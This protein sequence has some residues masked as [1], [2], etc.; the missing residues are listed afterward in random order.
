M[1][2]RRHRLTMESSV[3]TKKYFKDGKF[4]TGFTLFEVLIVVAILA[5]LSAIAVPDFISFLK[6]LNLDND[7]QEFVSVLRLAQNRALSS[8]N[9]MQY[10]VYIDTAISPNRYVLFE[11]SNYA[12]RNI[13]NDRIYFLEKANEFYNVNLG[14]GNEIV[15]DKLTGAPEESGSVSI[16]I[17]ID[18]SYSTVY[19]ENSGIVSFS[20]PDVV[21][22]DNRVKDS[23]HVELNYSRSI[24]I[25]NEN[26][27]LTFDNSVIKIIPINSYVSG[28]EFQW[29][30]AISV[31]GTD[32]RVEIKTHKLNDPDTLFSIH[33]DRRYNN[34]SL[35]ITISGDSSGSIAEYS[36]NGLTIGFSSIY[37]SNFAS[38]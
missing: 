36:A 29:Q 37:V 25:I 19:I 18:L 20:L 38:Q 33:R 24:D 26:I 5:V 34:K 12:S 11:G 30:G 28:G 10:G 23:R 4:L 17:K 8:E 15:F 9:Y 6:K 16:R 3:A 2:F 14:G 32:Q 7:V 35:K 13:S 22:D 27:V 31:G 21:S 1:D